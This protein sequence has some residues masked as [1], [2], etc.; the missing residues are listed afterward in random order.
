MAGLADSGIGDA[1]AGLA[2]AAD[3]AAAGTAAALTCATAAALVELTAGLA[4]VRLEAKGGGAPQG[5][6]GGVGAPPAERL[7]GLGARAGEV[8]RRMPALADEDVAL[9]AEVARAPDAGARGQALSRAADPPLKIAEDAAEIAEAAAEVLAAGSWPFTADAVVAS[10]L[11]HA[12]AQSG[13]ELV[14][15]NLRSAP[16]DPRIA[17]ARDAAARADSARA[18]RGGFPWDSQGNPP[19]KRD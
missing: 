7:R 2:S 8:R 11:A 12:A 17:R 18:I 13:A 14:G 6:G 9:Y 1:L 16:N 3:P 19:Q 10:E 5:E 15:A 4:S